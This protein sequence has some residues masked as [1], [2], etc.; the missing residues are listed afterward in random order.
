[1]TICTS[2]KNLTLSS[3]KC[4]EPSIELKIK[5]FKV[6][7]ELTLT[8][9]IGSE[10]HF[11]ATESLTASCCRIEINVLFKSFQKSDKYFA[12]CLNRGPMKK[13]HKCRFN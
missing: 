3:L 6:V 11:I 9:E 12:N 1:M 2:S 13:V 4:I 8:G 7:L 5:P 10:C